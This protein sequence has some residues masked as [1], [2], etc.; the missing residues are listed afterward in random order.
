MGP[1]NPSQPVNGITRYAAAVELL[2]EHEEAYRKM[3]DEVWPEV[4]AAI[5]AANIRNYSI[6]LA[7][8]GGRKYLFSYMEYTGTNPEADFAAIAQDP[9]TRD[10][11][12]PITDSF[13]RVI[14]GTPEGAQWLPMEMLMHIA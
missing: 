1:T 7:E 6:H 5:K 13:Q 9:T 11:W 2:P 4:V 14:E 12:W 3:H 8:I 10:R